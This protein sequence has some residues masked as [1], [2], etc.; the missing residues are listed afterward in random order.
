MSQKA[1]KIVAVIL[2]GIPALMLVFSSILKITSQPAMVESLSKVGFAPY[3]V[4]VGV[5]ELVFAILFLVPKT[6]KVGFLFVTSYLGGAAALEIAE[7]RAPIA[8]VFVALTWIG[9]YLME[10]NVFTAK[11]AVQ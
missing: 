1:Q 4:I 11:S 10:R 8:F 5:F 2:M 7:G 9:M 3:I 6:R